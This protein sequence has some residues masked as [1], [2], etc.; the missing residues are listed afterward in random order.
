M[1]RDIAGPDSGVEEFLFAQDA[2]DWLDAGNTADVALLDI[3][4][5]DMNGLVLAAKIKEKSPDTSIIFLTGYSQFAVDAFALHASGYLLKPVSKEKLAAEIRYALDAH[6]AAEQPHISAVTFGNFN[7]LVDGHPVAFA[8]AKSKE[9]LAY[10]IDRQ[11]STVTRAEAFAALWEDGFYD[12]SMQKQLD[13][14]LRSLR[15][16]LDGAGI[17]E[18][19]EVQR[20]AVPLYGRRYRRHQFLSWRIH[21]RLRLGRDDGRIHRKKAARINKKIILSFQPLVGH[22]LDKGF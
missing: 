10:L 8:R 21:E 4:M 2:L 5:P 7:L 6:P 16:T 22:L 19:L 14:I 13:V 11:G 18:I 15:A 12:R 17:G 3:D 20:G 1:C 9:L